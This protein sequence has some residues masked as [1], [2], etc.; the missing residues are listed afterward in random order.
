[1]PAMPVAERMTAREFLALPPRE[2]A[3]RTELVIA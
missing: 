3:A 2:E 1:M